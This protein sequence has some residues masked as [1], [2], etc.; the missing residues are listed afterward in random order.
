MNASES[1]SPRPSGDPTI[2]TA[3][4]HHD[5]DD[6]ESLSATVVSTVAELSGTEPTDLEL[7]YDRVDPDALDEIFAA[8]NSDSRR[9]DGH[10][11]FPLAGY[12]VTVYG[13]GF[14]VV[15]RLE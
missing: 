6:G 12:G 13:D 14:V 11:W 2:N 8:T 4:T 10:L 1:N 9:A 3:H 5:P 7:L 15:R